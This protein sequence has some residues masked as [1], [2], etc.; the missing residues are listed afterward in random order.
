MA[1][2]NL[3]SNTTVYKNLDQDVIVTNTDKA[4]LILSKHIGKIKKKEQWLTPLSLSI[5]FLVALLTA[6][7]NTFLGIE[8]TTWNAI[9]IIL[10]IVSFVWLI[11]SVINYIKYKDESIDSIIQ[12]FKNAH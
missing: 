6:T 2:F 5:T 1:D 10:E 8:G 11:I 7:F 3:D 4:A 12:E 9:F